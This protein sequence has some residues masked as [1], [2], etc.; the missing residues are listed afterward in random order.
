[1]GNT[2]Y[3]AWVA[4]DLEIYTSE[5]ANSGETNEKK[6]DGVGFLHCTLAFPFA[7]SRSPSPRNT[8]REDALRQHGL[9]AQGTGAATT[10]WVQK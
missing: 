5:K 6:K 4:F 2:T 8:I 9:Q 10:Q 3:F 1:M 7:T